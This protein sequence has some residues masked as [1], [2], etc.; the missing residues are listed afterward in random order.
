MATEA[1]EEEEKGEVVTAMEGGEQAEGSV[2]GEKHEGESSGKRSPE[3]T[4]GIESP[5]GTREKPIEGEKVDES[6]ENG[7]AAE[8]SAES[9]AAS[10]HA[11]DEEQV[12]P[13]AASGKEANAFETTTDNG[14]MHGSIAISPIKGSPGDSVPAEISIKKNT[15]ATTRE[16]MAD[17]PSEQD[18]SDS[19][20]EGMRLL[21]CVEWVRDRLIE[22][23]VCAEDQSFEEDVRK[24]TV[25]F[26]TSDRSTRL[27]AYHNK[28]ELVLSESLPPPEAKN[29]MYFMRSSG[30]PV[31]RENIWRMVQYGQSLA[32][33]GR[34][35]DMLACHREA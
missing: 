31:T 32:V 5:V 20:L 10:Q 33:H 12:S 27:F 3:S 34:E 2:Q 8:R 25:K 26:L 21:Q 7:D 18:P 30:S 9:E 28:G 22:S 19:A 23:N 17:L 29:A 24:E 4:S 15:L 11:D 16:I 6:H 1:E 13:D 14:N 35:S